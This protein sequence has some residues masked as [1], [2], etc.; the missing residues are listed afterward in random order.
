MIPDKRYRSIRFALA[1]PPDY[2]GLFPCAMETRCVA[3]NVVYYACTD[4]TNARAL[5]E[6]GD[7]TLY[8]AEEQTAG[9]GRHG[10]NWHSPAMKGLLFSVA[11]GKPMP[12]LGAAAAL[13]VR[14]ACRPELELDVKWPN[15]ITHGGRK[16]CGILIECRNDRT[17]LGVGLNVNHESGDFPPELR[18]QVA[19]LAMLTEGAHWDRAALLARLLKRL[20][21]RVMLLATE[22]CR[23]TMSEWAEA[24]CMRGK[25]ISRDGISGEVVDLDEQGALIVRTP[26]GLTRLDSG[27]IGVAGS[28]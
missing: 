13:A 1:D 15:D 18:K 14:E 4:S 7:G 17:A 28:V 27:E 9:R 6:G 2:P 20:D 3:R 23:R 5:E 26:A 8:I 21:E 22:G 24:C 11:F 19:S 10:R 12:G 25:W 16:V